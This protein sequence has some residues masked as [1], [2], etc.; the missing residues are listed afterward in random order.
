MYLPIKPD[1]RSAT[2][3]LRNFLVLAVALIWGAI[4]QAKPAC[5]QVEVTAA[6]DSKELEN[7]DFAGGMR[8]SR[9]FGMLRLLVKSATPSVAHIE[10]KK[11]RTRSNDNSYSARAAMIEEA[12]SGVVIKYRGRN[13]VVTNYHVIEGAEL[14]NIQIEIG[15]AHV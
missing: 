9:E 8:S 15:R 1:C 6:A 7:L 10:A 11:S 3:R 14:N 13:F 2:C 5:A 12:G 4:G